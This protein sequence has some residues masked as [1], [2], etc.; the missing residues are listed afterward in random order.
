MIVEMSP[1]GKR[2]SPSQETASAARRSRKPPATSK[3]PSGSALREQGRDGEARFGILRA[4]ERLLETQ[5]MRDLGVTQILEE[6]GISRFTFYAY[7]DSKYAVLTEL[8]G[9]LMDEIYGS[10]GPFLQRR[11]GASPQDSL[12]ASLIAGCEVWRQHRAVFRAI[13]EHW[14]AV[15]ELG[16]MWLEVMDRFKTAMAAEIER[17]RRAGQA[18]KGIPARKLATSLLWSSAQCMYVAGLGIDPD[19][20]DETAGT[21]AVVA[22][23]IGAVYGPEQAR[24]SRPSPSS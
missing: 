4:T 2:S 7:F 23:W 14:H 13:A 8:A 5:S 6:A 15:P 21:K 9:S 1:S 12:R 20:V 16:E 19:L 22:L 11:G 24:A 17:E 3:T 10:I 18:P